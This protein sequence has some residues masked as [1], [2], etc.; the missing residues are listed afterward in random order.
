VSSGLLLRGESFGPRLWGLE[1]WVELLAFL[2]LGFG[3]GVWRLEFG[4]WG[5]E[6]W[7]SRGRR[8]VRPVSALSNG[9]GTFQKSRV[10]IWFRV[11]VKLFQ[12]LRL[13]PVPLE[14]LCG[15]A[16]WASNFFIDFQLLH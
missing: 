7:V 1:L 14:S 12:T 4:Y 2:V 8:S 6:F 3:L 11:Q 9:L 16:W 13:V 15:R 10:N 5:S